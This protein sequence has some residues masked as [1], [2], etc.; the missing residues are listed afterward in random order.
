MRNGQNQLE[1]F[2][3]AKQSFHECDETPALGRTN[4]ICSSG[5]AHVDKCRDVLPS[6]GKLHFTII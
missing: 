2:I 1:S 3:L 5:L 4:W 6:D